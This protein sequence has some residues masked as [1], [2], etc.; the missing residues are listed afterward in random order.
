MLSLILL[1]A[2]LAGCGAPY[3][4]SADGRTLV[5]LWGLGKRLPKEGTLVKGDDGPIYFDS[6][7]VNKTVVAGGVPCIDYIRFW[8]TGQVLNRGKWAE[9]VST[10][11]GDVVGDWLGVPPTGA[12]PYAGGGFVGR[13]TLVGDRIYIDSFGGN[14]GLPGFT[15]FAGQLTADGF[16]LKEV[17]HY[18]GLRSSWKP[19]R[20]Q[21]YRRQKVGKMRGEPTW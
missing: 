6:L 9:A 5:P 4:I 7:Y 12:S 17:R 20:W 8:K 16:V 10:H 2:G 19:I 3:R 11:D 15:V 21:A 14:M 18:G 13:Y 1:T